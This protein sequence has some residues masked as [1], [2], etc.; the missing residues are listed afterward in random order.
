MATNQ[1]PNQPDQWEVVDGLQ[2][3]LTLANFVGSP[4]VRQAA[5]LTTAPLRLTDLD[6]LTSFEGAFFED[7]PSDIQTALE[8]RPLK[9]VV[10]NDKSDL[11]V[12]FD[13][14]ERLNT[15]GVSLTA[16][17]I[18]ECVFRGDFIELLGELT[19][20]PDFQ[21]V[22][23]VPET[24]SKDGT[25]EEFVLRFFAFLERYITFE[26]SVK[27]FLNG[28]TADATQD[29]D[30]PGRTTVFAR[31]FRFLAECFPEGLR[32]PH[33]TI[34]PVNLFEAV[35]V[36]AAMALQERPDLA[37]PQEMTWLQSDELRRMT[38]GGTNS[39]TRVRGRV[40]FCRHR[41]LGR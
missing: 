17:E 28:F 32:N 26:H 4:D 18:R 19:S 14:F 36:G 1:T 22:V 6:K 27:D 33:G 35:S 40:E 34:T 31:T 5:K 3:L 21:T 13:L 25:P 11:Q 38:T 29:P 23:R 9:V 12:R 10:L 15:G 30:V 24:R 2:R 7:L 16:Q 41:F 37:P 8:D 20:S 39:R